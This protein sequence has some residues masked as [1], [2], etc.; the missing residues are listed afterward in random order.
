M[1]LFFSR[2]RARLSL[3]SPPYHKNCLVFQNE[4][5]PFELKIGDA[6]TM[7][8]NVTVKNFSIDGDLAGKI[9]TDR[10]MNR[11]LLVSTNFY[12]H[13]AYRTEKWSTKMHAM[14]TGCAYI[15]LEYDDDRAA[16]A[17]RKTTV[18]CGV[19]P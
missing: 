9:A 1:N 16:G 17:L 8:S 7:W 15:A 5:P 3:V 19:L 10:T 13:V 11:T 4:F 18:W 2:V 14:E 6:A 12:F